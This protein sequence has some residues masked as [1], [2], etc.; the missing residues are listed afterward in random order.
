MHPEWQKHITACLINRNCVSVPLPNV[1]MPDIKVLTALEMWRSAG[2]TLTEDVACLK[3]LMCRGTAL[4]LAQM[5]Y[6]S[7]IATSYW[8]AV[9]DLV[10][11]TLKKCAM[12]LRGRSQSQFGEWHVHHWTYRHRAAEVCYLTDL[13]LLCQ[14]C[15]LSFHSEWILRHRNT[16]PSWAMNPNE[17]PFAQSKN[18]LEIIENELWKSSVN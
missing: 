11:H 16:T 1:M 8:E 14:R 3:K 15:H 2:N 7:F 9:R 13:T 4:P 18:Y 17:D 10:S 5:D 6:D 12:C